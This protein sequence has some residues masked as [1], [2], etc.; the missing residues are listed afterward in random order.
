MFNKVWVR[1]YKSEGPI[2]SGTYK[3]LFMRNKNDNIEELLS[4]FLMGGNIF[5]D[6]DKVV[7]YVG[8]RGG[9]ELLLSDVSYKKTVSV[10]SCQGI[11]VT[12]RELSIVLRANGFE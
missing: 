5:Q 12:P 2:N 8:I 11:N 1:E 7:Y 3:G 4:S 10:S 9:G 6:K